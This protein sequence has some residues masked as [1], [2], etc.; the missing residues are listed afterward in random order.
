[1]VSRIGINVR[2]HPNGIPHSGGS[3]IEKFAKGKVTCS[4][5][6]PYK[7]QAKEV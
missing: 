2:D 3:V 1:M 7:H 6:T 5:A 4:K